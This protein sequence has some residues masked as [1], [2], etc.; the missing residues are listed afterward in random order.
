M[1]RMKSRNKLILVHLFLASFL[2]PAFI[3]VAITGALDLIGIEPN[4]T[5]GEITLRR[6][7]IINPDSPTI[8]ADI[9][10]ILSRQNIDV[11]FESLR[12]RPT[13]ITTQPTSRDFIRF[14]KEDGIWSANLI[15]PDL[16]YSMMEL[17]KGHGPKAFKTYGIIS[18]IALF[19]VI[20]GGLIVGLLAKAYRRKT[21]VASGVGFVAF[22]LLGFML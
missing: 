1:N 17:H 16:Q 15:Q 12:V 6:D 11:H 13:R 21:I 10:Q 18:G 3:M 19:L 22:L 4:T 7:A 2:A 14:S 20:L 8:D 5:E 9:A